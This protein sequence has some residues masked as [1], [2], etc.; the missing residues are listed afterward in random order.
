MQMPVAHVGMGDTQRDGLQGAIS[1]N[2]LNARLPQKGMA[3]FLLGT[4]LPEQ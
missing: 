4:M 1:P 3:L 2:V